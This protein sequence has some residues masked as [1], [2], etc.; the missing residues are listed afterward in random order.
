MTTKRILICGAILQAPTS[1]PHALTFTSVWNQ[2][3]AGYAAF[4][5]GCG[6]GFGRMRAAGWLLAAHELQREIAERQ[7]GR[8]G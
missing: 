7:E 5:A 8:R 6:P 2:F 4:N 3:N 1:T